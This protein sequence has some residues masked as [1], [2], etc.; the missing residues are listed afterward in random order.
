LFWER[1]SEGAR[2]AFAW[3]CGLSVLLA[4]VAGYQWIDVQWMP[5][6]W[7]LAAVQGGLTS[8]LALWGLGFALLCRKQLLGL[9][10]SGVLASLVC[11]RAVILHLGDAGAEGESFFF[12]ALFW[13]FGLP[14]IVMTTLAWL[15]AGVGRESLR[16]AYQVGAMALGFVWA[17]F[18][19]QDYFGGSHLFGGT[20]SSTELYAYSVVWLLVAV[21]YQAIGLLRDQKALHVGSLLLLLLTIGKVFFVDASEL[22]GL[23]RVLSFLGL[24]CVLIGIGFFYNKVIFGRQRAASAS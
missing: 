23:Y 13:Q 20:T 8:V 10:G 1:W 24:G 6:A 3:W 19:V 5:K 22:E 14:F 15:S 11:L 18:L 7:T 12:N 2:P 16:R 21:A 9:V 4:V 17:S